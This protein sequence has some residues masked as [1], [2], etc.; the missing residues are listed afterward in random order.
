M[1][2]VELSVELV[3]LQPED[4]EAYIEALRLVTEILQEML[5]ED[6]ALSMEHETVS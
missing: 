5:V 3:P 1:L 2:T 6:E 4:V